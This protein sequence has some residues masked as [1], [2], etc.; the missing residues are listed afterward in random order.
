MY[1]VSVISIGA[2]QASEKPGQ[3]VVDLDVALRKGDPIVPEAGD[4]AFMSRGKIADMVAGSS[5]GERAASTGAKD[6]DVHADIKLP[7]GCGGKSSNAAKNRQTT[8]QQGS[9]TWREED[10]RYDGVRM[11]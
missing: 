7:N 1:V 9:P 10:Q 4:P 5:K 8:G 2:V 6:E 3:P 11:P